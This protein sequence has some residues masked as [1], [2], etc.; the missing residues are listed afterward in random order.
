MTY[1]Q[2]YMTTAEGRTVRFFETSTLK[3]IKEVQLKHNAEAAS[4]CPSRNRFVAGGED[5]WVHLYDFATGQV[6]R[7]GA[8]NLLQ[9]KCEVFTYCTYVVWM[10]CP[11]MNAMAHG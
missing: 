4:Y 10:D 9:L 11:A 5:M 7:L 6:G 8:G 2:Q 1:D 3:L